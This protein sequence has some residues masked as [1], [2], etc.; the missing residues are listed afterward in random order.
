MERV[1]THLLEDSKMPSDNYA[2]LDDHDIKAHNIE[3][4]MARSLVSLDVNARPKAFANFFEE[5][6]FVFTVMMATASTVSWVHSCGIITD[7]LRH[8][9]KV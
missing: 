6:V 2:A 9:F 7:F 5:I 3:V 4:D 1:S 8:S